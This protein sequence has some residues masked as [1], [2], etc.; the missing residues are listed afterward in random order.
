MT[1][2]YSVKSDRSNDPSIS[3]AI[4]EAVPSDDP[5]SKS[6]NDEQFPSDCA[7]MAGCGLAGWL[8]CGPLLAIVAALGKKAQKEHLF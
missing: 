4:A 2:Y 1:A 3:A 7:I 6:D 8:V 5:G